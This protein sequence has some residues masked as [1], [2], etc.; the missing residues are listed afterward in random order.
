ME[1]ASLDYLKMAA[2]LAAKRG[3][4]PATLSQF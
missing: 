1:T 4:S 3:E 2:G